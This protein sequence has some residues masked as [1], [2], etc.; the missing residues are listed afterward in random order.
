MGGIRIWS[1]GP[2]ATSGLRER[3]GQTYANPAFPHISLRGSPCTCWPLSAL[4]ASGGAPGRLALPARA[5]GRPRLGLAASCSNSGTARACR[6]STERLGRGPALARLRRA[7]GASQQPPSAR[8][9]SSQ[10][11]LRDSRS[12]PTRALD[13][14]RSWTA[15]RR[16]AERLRRG[17]ASALT[18]PGALRS[19]LSRPQS[20]NECTRASR[21]S[22]RY[23][24]R[25]LW[26]LN[27][28]NVLNPTYSYACMLVHSQLVLARAAFSLPPSL[29]SCLV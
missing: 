2:P 17:L 9:R 18:Q 21:S 19:R 15:C 5:A 13:R 7:Q 6:R 10:A 12:R 11:S 4:A 14:P 27:A 20:Q 24:R 23:V 25:D 29:F 22:M 1:T 3:L 28:L 8:S 16:S 26:R